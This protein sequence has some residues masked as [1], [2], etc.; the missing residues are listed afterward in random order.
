MTSVV[1][2][3]VTADGHELSIVASYELEVGEFGK[4]V[5]GHE[6]KKKFRLPETIEVDTVSY[7]MQPNGALQVEILLKDDEDE[8][9][10]DAVDGPRRYKC[11]ISTEEV[12]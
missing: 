11:D 7:Q 10:K 9:D 1:F 8:R 5:T 12:K 2:F 3:Q 4:Q 6:F